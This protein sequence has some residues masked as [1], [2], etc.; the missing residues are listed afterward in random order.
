M[1]LRPYQSDLVEQVKQAYKEG[2]KAPCIVLGCGGG[3]SCIV[4]DI[5]AKTTA[6]GNSVLFL[7]HR[8]EL[9]EQIEKTFTEWGVR[10]D[11]CCIGM[12][13]TIVRRLKNMPD[14]TLIIT[15][16]NHHSPA[17]TYK[18][19]Y[20]RFPNARRIG[21]TA[22]PVRLN[23]SGLGDVNDKLIIGVSTKYLIENHYLSPYDYYAPPVADLSGLRIRAGEYVSEDIEKI[24]IQRAVF[25]NVIMHYREYADGRQ[26][27]CYCAGIDHSRA[28]ADALNAAG[29]SAAHIDGTTADAERSEAINA[30]RRG[31]IRILC[32]VDLISEGFDVPD[33]SCV[34]LLRPTQSLVLHIQQTMR[35]MRYQPDKRAMILDHVGNYARH[36]MPD[37]E[38]EWTL[39]TK[40]KKEKDPDE[41]KIKCCPK[42]YHVYDPG[43][44]ARCPECGYAPPTKERT[45]E[46]VET[47]LEKIDSF[48]VAPSYRSCRTIEDLRKYAEYK[49]YKP[50]WVWYQSKLRGLIK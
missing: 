26:A 7:V 13:Q 25:G 33:C 48:V 20:E 3:K 37:A 14:P 32:N 12:V 38:R 2:C 27:I 43:L 6:K 31:D 19:I 17:A 23:G 30:F 5:A 41:V 9:C 42:C 49:H 36:G 18:K 44:Y 46:Y 45:I 24:M 22:T 10:M 40:P 16:E 21:V 4:A 28:T 1:E 8:R 15:D 35:C 47:K 34:I 11:L 39:D 50:G 29:I